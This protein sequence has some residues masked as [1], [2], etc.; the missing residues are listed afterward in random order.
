MFLI[1]LNLSWKGVS[2][3]FDNRIIVIT[4]M[5]KEDMISDM[6]FSHVAFWF[7]FWMS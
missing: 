4:L 3:F 5:K 2:G 7:M 1:M 6:D